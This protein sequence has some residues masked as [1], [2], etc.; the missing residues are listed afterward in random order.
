V[1]IS[2]VPLFYKPKTSGGRSKLLLNRMMGLFWCR[3]K[4]DTTIITTTIQTFYSL[5]QC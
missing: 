3:F 1:K 5:L 4:A 2:Y